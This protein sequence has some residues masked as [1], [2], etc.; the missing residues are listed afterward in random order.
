MA[1]DLCTYFTN[2]L[3]AKLGECVGEIICIKYGFYVIQGSYDG[4]C[5]RAALG[6]SGLALC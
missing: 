5:S 6:G 3:V 2:F 4:E 1:F